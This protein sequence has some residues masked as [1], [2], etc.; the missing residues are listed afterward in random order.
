MMRYLWLIGYFI[1]IGIYGF[2]SYLLADYT[3]SDYGYWMR[4]LWCGLIFS[5]MYWSIGL[6]Q[7][8]AGEQ[9]SNTPLFIAFAMKMILLGGIS[10]GVCVRSYFYHPEWMQILNLIT[11]GII[12]MYLA[13]LVVNLIFVGNLENSSAMQVNSQRSY[14]GECKQLFLDM[15]NKINQNN[16]RAFNATA[17]LFDKTILIVRTDNQISKLNQIKNNLLILTSKESDEEQNKILQQI[18]AQINSFYK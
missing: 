15:K 4:V 11:Q 5:L 8:K 9:N 1:I 13:L 12:V 7:R 10:I 3:A 16:S 6:Y 14:T 18:I 2:I 17:E